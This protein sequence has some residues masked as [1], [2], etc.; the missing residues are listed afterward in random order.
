LQVLSK[1]MINLKSFTCTGKK[2]VNKKHLFIIPHCFP[3]LEE[4]RSQDFLQL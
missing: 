3:L 1:K 2:C 4:L